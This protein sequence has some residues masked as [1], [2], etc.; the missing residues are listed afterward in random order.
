MFSSGS[1]QV[2]ARFSR[3]LLCVGDS[4]ESAAQPRPQLSSAAPR[5][6]GLSPG[7]KV[8][9][10]RCRCL[11]ASGPQADTSWLTGSDSGLGTV[12]VSADAVVVCETERSLWDPVRTSSGEDWA[13]HTGNPL[14]RFRPGNPPASRIEPPPGGAVERGSVI[15][16]I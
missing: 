3:V 15:A 13:D 6:C 16:S 7:F 12:R 2:L 10:C 5:L 14:R 11:G 4:H 8:S 9:S 1:P